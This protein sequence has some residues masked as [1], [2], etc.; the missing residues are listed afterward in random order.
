VLVVGSGGREHALAWKLRQSPQ[1]G[2]LFVAP[3]NGGTAALAE[4]V[5]IAES[6]LDALVDFACEK[7]IDLTVV[8]P[9]LPLSLGLADRLLAT[10]RPVFGPTQAAARLESSKVFAKEFMARH[11]IPTAD[12]RVA[13]DF[14]AGQTSI[15]ELG[16]PVAVK[17]DGLAAG[18]GVTVCR[19][20]EEADRA[21]HAALVE[22]K[23][24]PA[25]RSVVIEKGLSGQEVSVLAFCD[26]SKAVPM[27]VA[28]DHKAA[29]DGDT[30]PNTG[31]MGSY[32][33]APIIDTAALERIVQTVIEP[34]V[35]GMRVEGAPYRGVLY[36]GLMCTADGP[37]VLEFNA[38]F[39]DPETQSILPLLDADLFDILQS[40][41]EGNLVPSALHWLP[42]ACVCVVCASGGYPGTYSKGLPI[43]GLAEAGT[44]EGV[45][46]FHAG[47]RRQ[48][49]TFLTSGGR[50]LG[51]SCRA[52]DIRTA[53]DGAYRAVGHIHFEGMHY[54]R[55]IAAKA[56]KRGI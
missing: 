44:E 9:E 31:G 32:A 51:V 4:N 12:F 3:G 17:V 2:D 52:K 49:S 21:L 54:R 23:F 45:I 37:R 26:G 22:A 20:A 35:R 16:L 24:G 29:Y 6:D 48:D 30:G 15:R 11:D 28:Q 41:A 7:R 43:S 42:E 39:G 55:D 5:D 56:L 27:P 13:S 40:S 46:V 47:T 14:T 8:G 1:V 33:P 38:R 19:T 25:G 36:A 18:K 53:V 34:A 10:G 50:V